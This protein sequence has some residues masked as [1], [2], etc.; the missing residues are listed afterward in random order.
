MRAPAPVSYTHLDVYKRQVAGSVAAGGD[1]IA[2][3]GI[4]GENCGK[5]VF[6]TFTG[7][8]QGDTQIGG[9]AGRNQAS[10]VYKRQDNCP[11]SVNFFQKT[12][13]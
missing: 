13:N 3:G 1:K 12:S 4:A 5:I 8:V 10:D 6:C 7:M 2:C 9:I 11:R